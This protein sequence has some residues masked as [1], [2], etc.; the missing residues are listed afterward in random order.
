MAEQAKPTPRVFKGSGYIFVRE[1]TSS[2]TYPKPVNITNPTDTEAEAITEFVKE[3]A[4]A[5]N[6]LGY[7]KNGYTFATTITALSDQDDMGRLKIDDIQ[8]ETGQSTFSLFNANTDTIDS[9]YPMAAAGYNS[10]KKFGIASIGGVSNKKDT[11]YDI[12]FVHPDTVEGDICIY[13]IGKNITGLTLA[14]APN[15]VTPIPC[16]YASQVLDNTG[17]L[18]YITTHDPSERIYTP[19]DSDDTTDNTPENEQISTMSTK[20]KSSYTY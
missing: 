7:L 8:D 4:A 20:S 12:L 9:L 5:K 14:F 6:E 1:H 2:K 19:P 10:S 18:A 13:S 16:T 11:T 17:R 3:L 15:A